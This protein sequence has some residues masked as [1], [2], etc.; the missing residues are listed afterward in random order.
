MITNFRYKPFI[1][2]YFVFVCAFSVNTWSFELQV[3]DQQGKPVENAVVSIP[4]GVIGEIGD[5]YAVMDQVDKRFLPKV[6]AIKKGT[7]VIF[8]NSDNI[9]HH[10]YSFSK[11]NPFQI[12]LYK[13]VPK[14]PISF[15]SEGVV[16]LGCNIHDTMVGYIYVSPW[17]EFGI[18]NKEGLINFPIKENESMPTQ[19]E[20]WHPWFEN[21]GEKMTINFDGSLTDPAI[22]SLKLKSQKSTEPK[23]SKFKKFYNEN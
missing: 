10:V 23:K 2:I 17:P 1:R 15:N 4:R 19:I 5:D 18:S 7:Q 16:V 14:S 21:V 6:L 20:V 13:G 12:E 9:R 3:V 11:G 22:V 8:P